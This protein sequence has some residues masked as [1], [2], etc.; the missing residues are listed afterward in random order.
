MRPALEIAKGLGGS[1]FSSFGS[2][3]PRP[4]RRRH[5]KARSKANAACIKRHT[6]G[7][8][9]RSAGSLPKAPALE[10]QDGTGRTPLHVAAFASQDEAVE[11][12]AEAGADLNALENSAYDIVTMA[13]VADDVEMVNLALSQGAN[14]RN[15]TSPYGGTA[16]IAAAHLGHHEVVKHLM[17]AGAPLDH[18]NKLGWTALMEA[19][20]LSDGGS[21]QPGNHRALADAGADTT[22]ADRQGSR[23]SNTFGRAASP[24]SQRSWSRSR[25]RAIGS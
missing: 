21:D 14:A 17:A 6:R 22:L 8:S 5:R 12:L 7:T 23:R 2:Q 10:A 1:W 25:S 15:V 24:R 19:V 9:P 4:Y 13:A 11:A 16:L 18:V 3:C 20:V